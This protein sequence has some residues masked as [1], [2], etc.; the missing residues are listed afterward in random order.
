M[1]IR[2]S[3]QT[4]ILGCGKTFAVPA[5]P[6]SRIRVLD[7][8]VWATTSGSLDD[9][10]LR[11]GQE[12]TVQ[13]RGMTVIESA[14]RSTVELIPPASNEPRW[15]RPWLSW[16]RIP[17]WLDDVG[18]VIVLAAVLGLMTVAG[19]RFVDAAGS[20]YA[21]DAWASQ[22]QLGALPPAVAVRGAIGR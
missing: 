16:S 2:L 21:L 18:A 17:A 12:H 22:Y 3:F 13:R 7:G 15:S 5:V 6:G 11:K 9:V 19:Y 20:Q 1:G 10:W 8:L 14:G 4:I